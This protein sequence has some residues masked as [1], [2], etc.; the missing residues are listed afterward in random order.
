MNVG[1]KFL[2]VL[3]LTIFVAEA[4]GRNK[5]M[6]T[7][8]VIVGLWGGMWIGAIVASIVWIVVLIYHDGGKS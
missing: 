6:D 7:T 1:E 8:S 4:K 3:I 2:L 5:N